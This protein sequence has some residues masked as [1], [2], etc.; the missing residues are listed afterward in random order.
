[1]CRSGNGV[2][3]SNDQFRGDNDDEPLLHTSTYMGIYIYNG[4][5]YMY[6]LNWLDMKIIYIY[7]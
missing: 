7:I 4:Y 2:Y 3:P 1:M 6:E 5:I